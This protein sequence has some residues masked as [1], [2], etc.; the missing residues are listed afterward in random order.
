M[1]QSVTIKG[2]TTVF[3]GTDNTGPTAPATVICESATF[4]PVENVF[5]EVENNLG[6]TVI[7][8]FGDNGFNFVGEYVYDS[9]K[10]WPTLASVVTVK[11][12]TDGTGKSCLVTNKPIYET[13]V[14]RKGVAM[15]TVK[16]SYRPDRATS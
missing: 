9:A 3:F 16:A 13:K 14:S 12:P 5:A 11:S 4:T 1:P 7:E 15:I 6:F 10:T 2:I 8:I